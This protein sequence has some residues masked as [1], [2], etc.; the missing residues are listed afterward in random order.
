MLKRTLPFFPILI[1]LVVSS[2]IAVPQGEISPDMA[3]FIIQSM[4][5]T[6][7]TPTASPTPSPNVVTIIDTLNGAIINS[8]PLRETIET[9]FS[10][11]DVRFPMEPTSRQILTMQI[12]LEC[13]WIFTDSC[14]PEES[15]VNLMHGFAADDKKVIK[16]IAAQ[17]PAT[18]D[19]VEITTFNHR[20]P[21][22]TIVVNWQ[23]VF[24]FATGKITGNQL[25]ARILRIVRLAH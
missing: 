1:I 7:W 14:T 8:D 6:M 11:L 17:V 9:R 10:V 23:D 16:K 25:G 4:T 3:T 13:E 5:A 15:F 20:V 2:C 21:D 18:V 19:S 12:D 22:G 24:D